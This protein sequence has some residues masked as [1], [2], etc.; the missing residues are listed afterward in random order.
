MNVGDRVQWCMRV[1]PHEFFGVTEGRMGTVVRVVPVPNM[2][3]PTGSVPPDLEPGVEH[4]LPSLPG[5]LVYVV[6]DGDE[7]ETPMEYIGSQLKRTD[8]IDRLGDLAD[9]T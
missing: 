4:V 8:V 6:W 9:E 7:T 2:R 5:E 3:M 1:G